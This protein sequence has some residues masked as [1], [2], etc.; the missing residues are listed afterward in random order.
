MRNI[1]MT[2]LSTLHVQASLSG[3]VCMT[4]FK[5]GTTMTAIP[6]ADGDAMTTSQA[7]FLNSARR[8]GNK[9]AFAPFDD[10]NVANDKAAVEGHG[11]K[12]TKFLV[13]AFLWKNSHFRDVHG[14]TLQRELVNEY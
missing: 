6:T 3:F 11:C 1:S 9:K 13:V 7:G 10:F 2:I 8:H 12:R 14:H 5:T 4:R